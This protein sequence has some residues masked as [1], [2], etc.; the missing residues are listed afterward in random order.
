M[1]QNEI[2][3]K[4]AELSARADAQEQQIAQFKTLAEEGIKFKNFLKSD[5]LRIARLLG[6][7]QTV[8]FAL[9]SVE[10]VDK[11]QVILDEY[12][13]RWDEKHPPSGKGELA[14]SAERGASQFSHQFSGMLDAM[15][16]TVEQRKQFD[17]EMKK[18]RATGGGLNG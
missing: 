11:L 5:I 7:M 3:T 15:D 2:E 10:D 16:L 18:A 1:K 8:T 13:R 9:E 4:F 14:F 12:R 17:E 6:E